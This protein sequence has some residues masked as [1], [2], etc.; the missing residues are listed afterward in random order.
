MMRNSDVIDL[1]DGEA[2]SMGEGVFVLLQNSEDGPQ[3]IILQ[4]SDLEALLA[5]S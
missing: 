3:S 2:R 5:A 1:V 4:R